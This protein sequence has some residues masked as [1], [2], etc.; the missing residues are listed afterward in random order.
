[1]SV[2]VFSCASVEFEPERPIVLAGVELTILRWPDRIDV[3]L[4]EL[5]H[6]SNEE[7]WHSSECPPADFAAAVADALARVVTFAA[8]AGGKRGGK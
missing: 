2:R 6:D 3:Q 1:M 7:A 8:S 4:L 5:G